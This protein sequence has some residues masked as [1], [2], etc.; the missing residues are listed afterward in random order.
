MKLTIKSGNGQARVVDL[1]KDLQFNTLKGEQY[2]FSKGFDN[3]VLNFKDNQESIELIFNVDGKTI[4]VDLKGI[5]PHLQENVA[6]VE[7]P[8]VV[9]I[10]K[11]VNDKDLNSIVDN[12]SF[13][14]SEIIDRLE[15]LLSKPVELDAG[16]SD[17]T[18]ISDFQ[19]LIE[20]LDAAAAGA[21]ESNT[22]D[23]SS[24]QSL[25]NPISDSLRDV[26]QTDR[27]VNLS[28]EIS[29]LGLDTGDNTPPAVIPEISISDSV[30]NEKDG[31]ISFTI[32]L[33]QS[34]TNTVLVNFSTADGTAKSIL[35][36]INTSGPIIFLPGETVKTITIPVTNDDINEISENFFINLD[37]PINATIADDQAQG[38]IIDDDIPTISV[39]KPEDIGTADIIVPEGNDAVFAVEVSKAAVNST[40]TLT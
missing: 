27:W 35:D 1:E 37:T 23:G 7:N 39:G 19:T 25:F 31:E 4:K 38:T 5:V 17:L 36:Y 16:T 29:T 2:I 28:E 40:L 21:N 14:G 8:T 13:N 9:I 3:Y 15:E 20:A 22:S 12:D 32:S 30:V 18:L 26:A 11:N 33:S 24:F 34:T 10:N 6:G